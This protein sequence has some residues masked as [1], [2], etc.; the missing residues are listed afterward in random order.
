MVCLVS[1]FV[2]YLLRSL[3]VM[4]TGVSGTAVACPADK[5][6]QPSPLSC[7]LVTRM[8]ANA[9]LVRVWPEEGMPAVI[10]GAR[11]EGFDL[12]LPV[13]GRSWTVWWQRQ[14]FEDERM[15]QLAQALTRRGVLAYAYAGSCDEA[16]LLEQPTAEQ[17]VMRPLKRLL[18]AP[19]TGQRTVFVQVVVWDAPSAAGAEGCGLDGQERMRSVIYGAGADL[20]RLR[21]FLARRFVVETVSDTWG[22]C[23]LSMEH[24]DVSAALA[25]REEVMEDL[26]RC[27]ASARFNTL[28]TTADLRRGA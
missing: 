16:L 3:R 15:G 27:L 13:P 21:P 9:A 10:D 28:I 17:M 25:T 26:R 5:A 1:E 19:R 6:R 8:G 18:S 11:Q 14:D 12:Q 24:V 22:I 20:V 23:A 2:S 4:R 7:A